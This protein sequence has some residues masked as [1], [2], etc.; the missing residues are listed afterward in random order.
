MLFKKYKSTYAQYTD[1]GSREV[2]EDSIGVA[3]KDGQICCMLCDGLGGHGMGDVASSTA[4]TALKEVFLK[5]EDVRGFLPEGFTAAQKAIMEKQ[6][7]ENAKDKM[8]TTACCMVVDE[9]KAYIGHVG[10]SRVYVFDR[11]MKVMKRTLD[12]S[13]PQMLV[14]SGQIKESEIRHHP[15]RN[16]V[17]RSLGVE[18]DEDMYEIEKVVPLRKCKGFL[19]CSDG[20]WELIEEEEMCR[21]LKE[22]KSVQEWLDTMAEIVKTNGRGTKMDNNSAIAVWIE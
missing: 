4:V 7:Q 10:D 20:F 15:D 21:T 19:L 8:K 9:K 5:A 16:I 11:D 17:M 12:H 6:V 2:N 3:E 13:I 18:W 14:L 1:I 22:A